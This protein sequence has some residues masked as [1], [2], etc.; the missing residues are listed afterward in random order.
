M[1]TI[2]L[3]AALLLISSYAIYKIRGKNG[4]RMVLS[5]FSLAIFYEISVRAFGEHGKW[6]ILLLLVCVYAWHETRERRR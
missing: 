2:F 4:I 3:L 6:L 1:S 5:I